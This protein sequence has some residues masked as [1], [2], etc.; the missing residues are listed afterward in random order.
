[1]I[2]NF[3]FCS[4]KDTIF[5]PE[6][7]INAN[8]HLGINNRIGGARGV[9]VIVAGY[10]HGDTSSRPEALQTT[11]RLYKNSKSQTLVSF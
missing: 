11:F 4:G 8:Y 5:H 9:M 3:L 6:E 1:M 2:N 7:C 10:G